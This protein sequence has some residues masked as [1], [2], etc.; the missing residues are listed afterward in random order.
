MVP[1]FVVKLLDQLN[2]KHLLLPTTI[3]L[4]FMTGPICVH[5]C[6]AASVFDRNS[7]GRQ[8]IYDSAV[9]TMTVISIM[10]SK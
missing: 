2:T 8:H 7:A 10:R 1:L 3:R 4:T 5:R 6:G 9:V